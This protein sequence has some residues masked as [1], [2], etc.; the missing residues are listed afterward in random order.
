MLREIA[1]TPDVFLDS[2]YSSEELPQLYMQILKE[3]LLHEVLVRDL[4]NGDWYKFLIEHL[5]T[6]TPKAKELISKLRKQNRL[7]QFSA[8]NAPIPGSDTEWCKE[9]VDS[10]TQKAIESVITT[11]ATKSQYARNNLVSGIESVYSSLWWLNRSTSLR[12]NRTIG[13]YKQ[14]LGNI[15]SHANSVLFIDPYLDPEVTRYRC[16]AE[17][18]D[19]CK[20]TNKTCLIEVHRVCYEGSGAHR[21]IIDKAEWERRF[22]TLRSAIQGQ[23]VKVNVFIWDDFHDRYLV[24]NIAGIQMS[25]GYDE[26]SRR[27]NETTWSRMG[28]QTLNDVW[29]EFDTNEGVA[30]DNR[31]TLQGHFSFEF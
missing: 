17:L 31:H 4:H 25:N 15:L 26:D 5:G 27:D 12:L 24:S 30:V 7:K 21:R 16:F 23:K 8:V 3:P 1:I 11:S 9:A 28:R 20:G 10:S 22:N 18:L 14:R 13:N 19:I 6:W 2:S 29:R